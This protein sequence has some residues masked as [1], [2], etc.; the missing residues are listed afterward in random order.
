MDKTV[1]FIMR[2]SRPLDFLLWEHA[3][4]RPR[5]DQVLEVLATYQNDDGGFA[6]AIEP[7]NFSPHSTPMGTWKATT[8]LRQID[9]FDSGVPL[10]ARAIDYL[11]ATRLPDGYWSA[12]DPATNAFPHAEWWDDTGPEH[13]RWGINPTAGLLGYLLRPGAD[14]AHDVN[15]LVERYVDGPPVTMTEL[16]LALTL[17][18]DLRSVAL[19]VPQGFVERLASDIDAVLERDPARWSDYV[20]RPSTL[21][22]GRNADLAAPYADLIAGEKRYLMATMDSDGS[23]EPNWHWKEHPSEWAVARNWW[24][25]ILAREYLEFLDR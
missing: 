19:P 3:Q 9:C 1:A 4:G 13:R 23:W 5:R 20:V 17:H 6:R 11:T 15:D 18:D 7:D 25:A 24:K 10:V 8:V 12:T 14:V 22:N 21:F 16:P 2:N